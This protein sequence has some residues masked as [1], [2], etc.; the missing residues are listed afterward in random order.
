[1][2]AISAFIISML[3]CISG[4]SQTEDFGGPEANKSQNDISMGLYLGI[5]N[6]VSLNGYPLLGI[7]GYSA[8][9][10][11]GVC[12]NFPLNDKW[13]LEAGVGF[14]SFSGKYLR[15]GL[16][17]PSHD[18]IIDDLE[19]LFQA[20][21]ITIPLLL[22]YKYGNKSDL[23]AGIR[24]SGMTSLA[25]YSIKDYLVSQRHYNFEPLYPSNTYDIPNNQMDIGLILGYEYNLSKKWS[26]SI[27]YNLGLIPIISNETKSRN[28]KV[29]GDHTY[30]YYTPETGNHNN[31][32]SI[33][34]CYN[35]LL[36]DKNPPNQH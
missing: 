33:R 29:Y 4:F 13:H 6:V 7:G 8:A 34:L 14:I 1:M 3:I 9:P 35:F 30:Y 27:I 16:K 17:Y 19:I 26:A 21:Y 36:P 11:F 32:L 22:K 12:G 2:K 28:N 18:T 24:L 25:A 31:S 15:N 5:N 23:V 10:L 20:N